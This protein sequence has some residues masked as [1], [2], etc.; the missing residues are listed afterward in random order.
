MTTLKQNGARL[1]KISSKLNEIY[2]DM[3][4][5]GKLLDLLLCQS[6]LILYQVTKMDNH[7][8]KLRRGFR[9]KPGMTIL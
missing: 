7:K 3:K 8:K 6:I 4:K 1:Y 2:I 9:V 5:Q